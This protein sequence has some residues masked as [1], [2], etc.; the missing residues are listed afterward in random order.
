MFLQKHCVIIDYLKVFRCDWHYGNVCVWWWWVVCRQFAWLEEDF[1]TYLHS[2]CMVTHFFS[3][4]FFH[5]LGSR[6]IPAR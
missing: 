3:E 5:I 2:V 6:D 4:N 1:P